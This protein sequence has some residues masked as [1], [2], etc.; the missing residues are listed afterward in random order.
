MKSRLAVLVALLAFTTAVRGEA[1]GPPASAWP[2]LSEREKA[3]SAAHWKGEPALLLFEEGSVD[4]RT[5]RGRSQSVHRRLKVL[6]A[7]GASQARISIAL[8][9]PDQD[10]L[11][12]EGRTITADGREVALDPASIT[13]SG[14]DLVE[15]EFEL[16]E[17]APGAVLEYRY[18]IRGGSPSPLSGWTFQHEIPCLR[19][20]FTWQPALER[21]SHWTLMNAEDLG[22][23]VKPLVTEATPDSLAA[24][25]FELKDVPAVRSEP[26]GPPLLETRARLVTTYTDFAAEAGNYWDLFAAGARER[27]DIVISERTKLS[28]A[29]RAEGK[30]PDDFE[31]RIRFAYNFVQKRI[32]NRPEGAGLAGSGAADSLFLAGAADPDGINLLFIAALASLDIAATRAFVVDRD[33]GFFHR[34]IQSPAQFSRSIVAVTPGN[35]RVFFF[36]PGTPGAPPGL[37]P[38]YVQG[39]TALIVEKEHAY[40]APTPV[41]PATTNQV[42]RTSTLNLDRE[43]R[44]TA[45]LRIAFTG[46]A[47]LE[48]RT[49]HASGPA[50]FRSSLESD[51]KR[52][53]GKSA[54]DSLFVLNG[55]DPDRNLA[56]RSIVKSDA[57]ASVIDDR[58][59]MNPAVLGRETTNPFPPVTRRSPVLLPY[60]RITTDNVLLSLP[61][62]WKLETLPEPVQFENAVGSYRTIWSF[63]GE[64][65]NYQRTFA[66]NDAL[67]PPERYGELRELYESAIEG[68]RSLLA[69]AR[70]PLPPSKRQP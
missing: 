45:A 44:L 34:E 1:A 7:D 47:E 25:R 40:F 12:L 49:L 60:A 33:Q 39:I 13:R 15:V 21:T 64:R 38:W 65:I 54:V 41:D 61:R 8:V 58:L 5:E 56:V 11:Y 46:Q 67:V 52:R 57:F 24:V 51:W 31:G 26:F 14:E 69:L 17:S 55:N 53:L 16:P 22:P 50:A 66:L 28:E 37:L 18:A 36:S 70:A 4:D 19:S 6:T 9:Q 32:T 68:D 29:I 35:G 62:G 27:Q 42:T 63:D 2:A 3:L 23:I 10:L 48:A 59:L 20:T 30:L 43:G